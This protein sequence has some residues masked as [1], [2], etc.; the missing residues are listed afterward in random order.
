MANSNPFCLLFK[1][2]SF[3]FPSSA[4]A[5][6]AKQ[7]LQVTEENF[8]SS[9]AKIRELEPGKGGKF[10][11]KEREKL[12]LPA[13]WES[14]GGARELNIYGEGEQKDASSFLIGACKKFRKLE[15]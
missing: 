8:S 7:F 3:L 5:F 12:R 15:I 13:I 6:P 14:R 10:A 1:I 9:S 11:W 2:A 4:T